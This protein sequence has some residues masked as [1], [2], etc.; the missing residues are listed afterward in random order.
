MDPPEGGTTSGC[1]RHL[2]KL[3]AILRTAATPFLIFAETG[4]VFGWKTSNIQLIARGDFRPDGVLAFDDGSLAV[5]FCMPERM[6]DGEGEGV[7]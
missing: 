1:R 5:L 3:A 2:E 6:R 4:R 7:V